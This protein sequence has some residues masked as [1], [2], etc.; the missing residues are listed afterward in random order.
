[1]AEY[2]PPLARQEAFA[3]NP[4]PNESDLAKLSE[5]DLRQ[6]WGQQTPFEYQTQL[7]SVGLP[8]AAEL[9]PQRLSQFLLHLALGLMIL[10]SVLAWRMDNRREQSPRLKMAATPEGLPRGPVHRAG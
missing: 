3:V 10:E 2:G 8:P 9:P 1:M 5:A 7:E 4:D 6:M